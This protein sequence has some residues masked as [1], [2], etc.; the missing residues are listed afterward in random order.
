[1]KTGLR[2]TKV[3]GESAGEEVTGGTGGMESPSEDTSIG[4]A[5]LVHCCWDCIVVNGVE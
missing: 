5:T 3:T 4:T 1:M 2:T